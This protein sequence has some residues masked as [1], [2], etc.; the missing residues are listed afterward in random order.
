MRDPLLPHPHPPPSN[1][2][3]APGLHLSTDASTLAPNQN[4]RFYPHSVF[5][6][7]FHI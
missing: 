5:F 4:S 7:S 2:S 6:L 1:C 3:S